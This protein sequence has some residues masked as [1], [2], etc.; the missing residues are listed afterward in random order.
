MLAAAAAVV[1]GFDEDADGGQAGKQELPGSV[2]AAKTQ[3]AQRKVRWQGGLGDP[4]GAAGY[5][6]PNG[7][8]AHVR[9]QTTATV[10][11]A[12]LS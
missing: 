4:R 9:T 3:P 6:V 2:A 7:E 12:V 11:E 5:R 10:T 1:A 8:P